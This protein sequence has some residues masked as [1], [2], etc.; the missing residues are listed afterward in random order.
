[1]QTNSILHLSKFQSTLSL[2]RATLNATCLLMVQVISIHALLAESDLFRSFSPS[3][4]EGISIH[5]LLAES[6]IDKI[7][8][9]EPQEISIHALLAESDAPWRP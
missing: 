6:D 7:K 2:R 8:G 5:A 1:M 3:L 4:G 9:G